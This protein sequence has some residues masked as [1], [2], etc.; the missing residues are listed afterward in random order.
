MIREFCA[1]FITWSLFFHLWWLWTG[2]LVVVLV[3]IFVVWQKSRLIKFKIYYVSMLALVFMFA[4]A[5]R[6]FL[7]EIYTIPSSSMENTLFSGDK[8]LVSKL[9]YGPRMP[10]SPFDIPWINILFYLNGNAR[11]RINETW[12]ENKRLNGIYKVERQDVLVFNH[13]DNKKDHFIKRCIGLPGDT[14]EIKNGKE[15]INKSTSPQLESV[16]S[17]YELWYNDR[18]EAIGFLDSQGIDYY[19]ILKINRTKSLQVTLSPDQI[20][21]LENTPSIDSITLYINSIDKVPTVFPWSEKYHWTAENFGPVVIPR[22]GMKVILNKTNID[23]YRK[24]IRKFD[25][26]K[27]LMNKIDSLI[28]KE[29]KME[30]VFL[31]NYYFLMGDNRSYSNDSRFWGFVPEDNIIGNVVVV[32]FST[33]IKNTGLSRVLKEIE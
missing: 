21:K 11:E 14:L 16:K 33:D 8:V 1:Y 23:L 30:Y 17:R 4:V 32:L 19:E 22:L 12:W 10:N 9:K 24:A 15:Y 5:I 31:K 20:L 27:E 3:F 28:L 29:G 25:G 6:I 18:K 26:N 13:V 7:V 2:I